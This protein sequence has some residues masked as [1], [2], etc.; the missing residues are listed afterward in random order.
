ML[1]TKSLARLTLLICLLGLI[2]CAAPAYAVDEYGKVY[3][4]EIAPALTDPATA[5]AESKAL[6]QSITLPASLGI[7][8]P[9]I[10]TSKVHDTIPLNGP[11]PD[12]RKLGYTE[13]QMLNMDYGD[14]RNIMDQQ[15]LSE[16]QIKLY[17]SEKL[18]AEKLRQMTYGEYIEAYI[19]ISEEANLPTQEQQAQFAARNITL[20]DAK[21][22]CKDFHQYETVLAQDDAL[23]KEYL[24]GYYQ[25]DIDFVLSRCQIPVKATVAT[26][27]KTSATYPVYTNEG[28]KIADGK[29]L[30]GV[31]C[32]PM[33][34]LFEACG[35][36][37]NWHAGT[38]SIQAHTERRDRWVNIS[39]AQQTAELRVKL[40]EP[41]TEGYSQYQTSQLDLDFNYCFMENGSTYLPLRAIAEALAVDVQWNEA[42][43]KVI[44][45]LPQK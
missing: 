26:A 38:K 3:P 6:L 2:L 29:V 41:D 9:H 16:N 18:P 40:P 33:R 32:L 11:N 37:V 36:T 25:F 24:E 44:L 27:P 1:L 22:L 4:Q 39:L 28:Q 13:A 8:I 34:D 15:P 31:T 20:Q 5:S 19:K 35:A 45:Q 23:L 7:T 10:D 30:N 17:A 14:F 42:E 43:K 12:L 21:R